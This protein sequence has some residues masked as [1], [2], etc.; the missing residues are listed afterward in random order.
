M[1]A[2]ATGQVQLTNAAQAITTPRASTAFAIKA[3]L[4][5]ARAAFIG[6][7]GVTLTTGHQLDPGDT[8]EYERK[9]QSGQPT[10]EISIGDL[11]VCGTVG[12]VIS[13]LASP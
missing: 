13:W 9:S 3:P 6:P 1:A 10:Y 8:F 7:V 2:P 11:Y 4:S 5:N 12:D